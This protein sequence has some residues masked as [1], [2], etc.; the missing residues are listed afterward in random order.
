[1]KEE[2]MYFNIPDGFDCRRVYVTE[3]R[4]I[5]I[6]YTRRNPLAIK[7]FAPSMV[8]IPKPIP[9]IGGTEVYQK[10]N[11]TPYW[12]CRIKEGRDEFMH[13]Y[14]EDL[15]EYDLLYEANGKKREFKT[16]KQKHFKKYVLKAL[17]NKP[18]EGYRWIPVF[19]PSKDSEGNLQYV[20][21]KEVLRGI[22]LTEWDNLINSYSIENGSQK[23]SIT[24]YFLMA[25]RWLKDGVATLEQLAEDSKEL[26]NYYNS[27]NSKKGFEE[28]GK[29]CFGGLCGFVGNTNKIV[30]DNDSFSGIS[31]V[32]A[33]FT[34]WG[35]ESPLAN[36]LDANNPNNN[37]KFIKFF[38][39]ALIELTK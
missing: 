9:L 15:T 13:L 19:E 25:L 26:G 10:D 12:Y 31:I 7:E 28:A 30:I 35:W 4:R 34:C 11:G 22:S 16:E 1:M 38:C 18:I 8:S 5:G 32:G 3:D 6:V 14:F 36:V 17:N 2:V 23:A 21:G 33:N 37:P 39:V 24:T 27:E 29:R 20:S